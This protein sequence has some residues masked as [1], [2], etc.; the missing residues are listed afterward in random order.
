MSRKAGGALEPAGPAAGGALDPAG[1]AAGGALEP[2][3]ADGD[4]GARGV[5]LLVVSL[6]LAVFMGRLD[7]Y[8]VGIALPTVA[9]DFH[10]R[11]SMVAWVTIGYLLFNTG[12]MLF[13][14]QLAQRSRPRRLFLAGYAVFVVGALVAALSPTLGVLIAARCAQG[15]GGS[16]MVIMTYSA[17]SRLLP[18]WVGATMGLL[19]L[20]GALGVAVGS[21]LGGVLTATLSWRWVFFVNVP[22]GV[23]AMAVAWRALP[24]TDPA[25]E[26]AGSGSA[27][28]PAGTGDAGAGAGR[29]DYAGGALSFLAL[30]ALILFLDTGQTR[31]WV[32]WGSLVLLAIAVVGGALFVWNESR[33]ARPLVAPALFRDRRV[34]VVA[35]ACVAGV[36][37]MGGNSLLVPFFLQ[38][39]KGM[40][41]AQAGVLL[42]VYSL[43]FMA[44]SPYAGRLADRFAPRRVSAAGMLVGVAAAGLLAFTAAAP[45]YVLVVAYLLGLAV[46]YALFMPAN[47]KQVLEA[48]PEE[49]RAAGPALLGT[50]NTLGLLLG[51]SLFKTAFSASVGLRDPA[52]LEKAAGGAATAAGSATASASSAAALATGPG[53][54]LAGFSPA[55]L[56]GAIACGVALTLCLRWR[57]RQ[58]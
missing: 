24:A 55:Y 33:A 38:L 20:A 7:I 49:H 31:G 43:T 54:W 51:A 48:P 21:P 22:V 5:R 11:T 44:L 28:A 58:A 56:T 29:L 4:S 30:S 19:A 13:V 39:G 1:P 41:T 17:V 25:N 3:G 35:A 47:S 9:R 57:R 18:T 50:L 27:A 37:L 42:L 52:L 12:T 8:L 14:G 16:I 26:G 40:G 36:V 34:L 2:A 15:L 32:S 53:W 6:A 10:V 46:T 45:G 23:A